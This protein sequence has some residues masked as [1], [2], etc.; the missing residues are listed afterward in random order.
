MLPRVRFH[1]VATD[2]LCDYVATK[3]VTAEGVPGCEMCGLSI[4]ALQPLS[5]AQAGLV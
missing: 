1:G 3:I 4:S 5:V 2:Q